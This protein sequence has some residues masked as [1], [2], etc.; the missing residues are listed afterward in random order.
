[1]PVS[2]VIPFYNE[3]DGVEIFLREL[4]SVRPYDEII[5]VDDGSTDGTKEAIRNFPAV[6]LVSYPQRKGQSFA[7]WRGLEIATNDVCVLMDGDGETDPK[8]IEALVSSMKHFDMCCGYRVDR[9][10]G[11]FR[12]LVSKAAN[13][14]R[15][16]LLG[17]TVIDAGAMKAIRKADLRGLP[18]FDGLH[19][20]LPTLLQREGRAMAQVPLVSRKRIAGRSRYGI[21]GRIWNGTFDLIG[22]KWLLVRRARYARPLLDAGHVAH[23]LHRAVAQ[24]VHDGAGAR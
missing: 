5:A 13:W 16:R 4:L 8:D 18:L 14:T 24:I 7:V 11:A 12:A 20:Y 21:V 23:R 10:C 6:K 1:M 3:K 19:R 17:D 9:K 2:I 15:R 22:V